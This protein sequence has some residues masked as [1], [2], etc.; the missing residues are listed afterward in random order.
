M[1]DAR[2]WLLPA[3]EG[4]PAARMATPLTTTHSVDD[5][6]LEV[7]SPRSENALLVIADH[8]PC[9]AWTTHPLCSK[10]DTGA[11]RRAPGGSS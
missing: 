1:A 6:P 5:S 10:S 3:I 8:A 4:Q 7:P 2:T 11:A 9:N